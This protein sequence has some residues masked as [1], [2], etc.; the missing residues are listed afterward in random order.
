MGNWEPL[1]WKDNLKIPAY[2]WHFQIIDKDEFSCN[3]LPSTRILLQKGEEKK[4]LKDRI[5]VFYS[6]FCH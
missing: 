6:Q 1:S 2:F 3:L 4:D 5:L